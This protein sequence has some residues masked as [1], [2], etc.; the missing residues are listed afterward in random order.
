MTYIEIYI[1]KHIVIGMSMTYIGIF[2]SLTGYYMLT[3]HA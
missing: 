3:Y 2:I 1:G